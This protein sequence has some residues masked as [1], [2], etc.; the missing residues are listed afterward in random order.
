MQDAYIM[1]IMYTRQRG[2][3]KIKNSICAICFSTT[4]NR[5]CYYSE[6]PVKATATTN[7]D[8]VLPMSKRKGFVRGLRKINNARLNCIKSFRCLTVYIIIL[9][10]CKFRIPNEIQRLTNIVIYHFRS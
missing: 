5:L 9:L 3:L 10:N 6:R 8:T 7:V 4:F 1:Y 2:V